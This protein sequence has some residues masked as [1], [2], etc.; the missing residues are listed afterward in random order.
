M[1]KNFPDIRR[2]ALV[3]AAAVILCVPEMLVGQAR[4]KPGIE[5]LRDRGFAMLRGKRVGLI[6]NPTGITSGFQQTVDVL[7]GAPGVQLIALFGDRKS[8]V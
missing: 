2:P 1:A 8:V 5:V 3:I 6:T 7:A 4:V